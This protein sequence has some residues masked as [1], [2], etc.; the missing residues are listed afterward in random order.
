M[1]DT[2]FGIAVHPI[3]IHL[4]SNTTSPHLYGRKLDR[5]QCPNGPSR[6]AG[7]EVAIPLP[8]DVF[9]PCNIL[10]APYNNAMGALS[11]STDVAKLQYNLPSSNALGTY[12]NPSDEHT[13]IY[14][15]DP[16]ANPQLDFQATAPAIS[17]QCIPMTKKCMN[18]ALDPS[19]AYSYECTKGFQPNFASDPPFDINYNSSGVTDVSARTGIAFAT[20]AQLSSIP[21]IVNVTSINVTWHDI[22]P[23][24]PLY[25]G[26]WAYNYP[27]TSNRATGNII[28]GDGITDFGD[29]AHWFLNCTSTVAMATYTW[30]NGTVASFNPTPASPEMAAMIAAQFGLRGTAQSWDETMNTVMAKL[31]TYAITANITDG[32]TATWAEQFSRNALA[33]VSGV[34]VPE[35]TIVEQVRT[36]SYIVARVPIIPLYLL[37]AFKLI[38]VVSVIALAVGAYAFTHPAE[39]EAVKKQLSSKGLAA[40]HFDQ[41]GLVQQNVV[42]V[43]RETLTKTDTSNNASKIMTAEDLERAQA[44]AEEAALPTPGIKRAATLMEGGTA[45]K[46]GLVPDADGAWKYVLLVDGVWHSIKPVVDS[47]VGNEASQGGFGEVGDVWL[48]LK[49]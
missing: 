34:F 1:I 24:N 13:W 47:F 17:T 45:P 23:Q 48:A 40:A 33:L 19:Y 22:V 37:L 49:K 36:A 43:L 44:E 14:L 18:G 2:W 6:N 7:N 3:S 46:V 27:S 15:A 30:V 10:W 5:T 11:G 12:T 4:L 21:P 41:P 42:Q 16:N 9:W 29:G 20:D 38:Y 26:T 8:K 35:K 39:T 25:F 32:L 31:A 28:T